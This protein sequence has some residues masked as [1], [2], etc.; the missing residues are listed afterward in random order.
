MRSY[1]QRMEDAGTADR[2]ALLAH[3][4]LVGYYE[5]LGFTNRG[6]SKATFGGGGWY[7]LV[8]LNIRL[9]EVPS[10]C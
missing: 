5:K 6:E 10:I 9:F 7:D 2:L 8:S 4:H 1:I 3:D